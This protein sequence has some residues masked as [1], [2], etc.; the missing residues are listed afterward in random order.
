MNRNNQYWGPTPAADLRWT[1]RGEPFSRRFE[2]IY[3]SSEDGIAES[4]HV[5]LAGNDLARRLQAPRDGRFCIGETGFGTGLNFLLSWQAWRALPA[6]RPRLHYIAI[7]KFPLDREE[8][9]RALLPWEELQALA[10]QLQARWPGRLPGQHRL[11]FEGGALTLDLWWEDIAAALPDLAAHGACVDA[12]YLDGFAPS[13]NDAMWAQTLYPALAALSRPG[14]TFATFTAA[15]H[16][17]RGLAAVGFAARKVPGFGRKRE[18]LAGE[19]QA[20]SAALPVDDTPWDLPSA[21]PRPP[22]SAI[23]IGAGLAGCATARALACRG[24]RV[25]LLER[26]ALA[27]AASGNGQGILYTRLSRRH[28]TLT[29]FALQS[30]RHASAIYADLFAA[31]ALRP[32]LDG[33]LCGMFHLEADPAELQDL[34][35]RLQGLEDLARPLDIASAGDLLGAAPA[36]PG[37]W[38]PASGW[39]N[40]PAVCRAF[41]SHPLIEIR[42][43]CGALTL[44]REAAHWVAR[45]ARGDQLAAAPVAVVCG[46]TDSHHLQ[47]L[48]WLPLRPIRGQTTELPAW[49]ASRQLRAAVCDKGYI[50][51]ARDGIHTM[52]ASFGP[53][54]TALDF[55]A[56]EQTDNLGKLAAALPGWGE[57]LASLDA[58][59]L[60]GRAGLRCAS[61]DYLPLAGPVPDRDAFLQAYAPLRQNAQLVIDQRG[62]FV[63]GLYLNTAHGSRGLCSAPLCA[64]LVASAI[65]TE[66][67]P[68]SRE[69][70][71]ALSPAR[72]LLR[73]L[74][75]NRI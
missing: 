49:E 40:P 62:A 46:G 70:L 38:F 64:E 75:R 68:L 10:A 13:R 33:E 12:W 52:G 36:Q 48:D 19:L 73:D 25:Q 28:S 57:H 45:N 42:T 30:F 14:A 44:A 26:G 67:P 11:V 71:R 6:P 65:V 60:P 31:G 2:D 3:F 29:D 20:S 51:P 63:P 24:I 66:A 15:G 16:V 21:A 61:P 58:A 41:A 56:Q 69:L 22:A 53:G 39:L 9:A 74:A 1:E 4:R 47:H 35:A 8:L 23:V 37:F 27:G 34:A 54:D 43:D 5:F 72:F 32:G 50:A 18:S 17:R 7:E 59:A 55:R